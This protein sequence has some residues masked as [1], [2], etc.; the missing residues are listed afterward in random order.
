MKGS[1]SYR[2]GVRWTAYPRTRTFTKP[3]CICDGRKPSVPHFISFLQPAS[4][5]LRAMRLGN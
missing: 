1:K 5:F 3:A 2:T 4:S